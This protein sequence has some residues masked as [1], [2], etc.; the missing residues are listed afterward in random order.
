M[1]FG[2]RFLIKAIGTQVT[3]HCGKLLMLELSVLTISIF[4]IE[5]YF[6]FLF[7]PPIRK[8]NQFLWIIF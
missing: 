6:L 3:C 2:I 8:I 4:L 7:S 5:P 1:Q